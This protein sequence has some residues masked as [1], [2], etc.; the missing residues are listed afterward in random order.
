MNEKFEFEFCMAIIR[1]HFS[2]AI[3]VHVKNKRCSSSLKKL[4]GAKES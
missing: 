2:V 1:K 3:F 4:R